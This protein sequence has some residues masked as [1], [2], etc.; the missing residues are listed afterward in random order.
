MPPIVVSLSPPALDSNTN[1]IAFQYRPAATS[2]SSAH[3]KRDMGCRQLERDRTVATV[4]I[5][6]LYMPL[7]YITGIM[8]HSRRPDTA[9][10]KWTGCPPLRPV[11]LAVSDRF[12]YGRM[13]WSPQR[14]HTTCRVPTLRGWPHEN[15]ARP[16]GAQVIS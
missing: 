3:G 12:G 4:P 2:T 9:G 1:P 10:S 8:G 5:S 14:C 16:S 6:L 7:L 13:L 11:R 15:V